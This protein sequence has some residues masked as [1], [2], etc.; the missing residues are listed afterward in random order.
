MYTKPTPIFAVDRPFLY[1]IIY[2]KK[3]DTNSDSS[4]VLFSGHLKEPIVNW[5]LKIFV[6]VIKN[7]QLL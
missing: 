2:H 5:F 4:T 7:Y 1:S 6:T 3:H